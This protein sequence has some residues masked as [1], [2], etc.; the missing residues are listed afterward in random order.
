MGGLWNYFVIGIVPNLIASMLWS[1][2]VV[3][4]HHV[5]IKRHLAKVVKKDGGT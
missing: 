4:V 5:L 2:P 3:T 1:T